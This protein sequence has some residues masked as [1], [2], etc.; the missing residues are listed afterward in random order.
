MPVI[1][2]EIGPL[3]REKKAA[4]IRGFVEHASAVTGLPCEVFV[5][6]IKENALE[7]V[8]NGVQ[9]LAEKLGK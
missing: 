7:N 5:T 4:L 2:L 6:I 1:T 8:G 9:T 3:T